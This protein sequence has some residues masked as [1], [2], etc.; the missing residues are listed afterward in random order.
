MIWG[1]PSGDLQILHEELILWYESWYTQ[2]HML[3]Q[4]YYEKKELE[5]RELHDN[6]EEI[7]ERPLFKGSKLISYGISDIIKLK[8]YPESNRKL[9]IKDIVGA[10]RTQL[11]IIIAIPEVLPLCTQSDVEKEIPSQGNISPPIEIKESLKKFREDH[12]NPKEV[13]FIMMQFGKTASHTNILIAIRKTFAENGL[14]GV[15]ADDKT[16]HDDN[17]YNILTYLHGCGFGVAAFEKITEPEFNPNISL[18]VGYLLSLNKPICLLKEKS[19]SS[20]HSDLVGKLYREFEIENCDGTI[21][22][23][24]GNWIFDKGLLPASKYV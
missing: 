20:L 12:P 24:L 21:S 1:L 6:K 11:G 14:N 22:R 3:I 4:T 18:E 2:S 23:D 16:Y 13:G 8:A 19:L 17:Y 7:D 10:F 15:R 9:M 5:F